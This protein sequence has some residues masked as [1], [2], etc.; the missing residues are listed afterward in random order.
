MEKSR[1]SFDKEF[2]NH[3]LASMAPEVRTSNGQLPSDCMGDSSDS[4]DDR[5]DSFPGFLFLSEGARKEL[6]HYKYRGCDKS[7]LY[8]YIL[9]PLAQWLVD[10]VV[11]RN[12]AP[13]TITL[14]G[15]V[16]MITAYLAYWFYVPTLE[17]VE[18]PPR[19]IFLWNSISILAYQTLDN[20][21]GKQARRTGS[22]SPLGLLF[23]H[24]CDAINSTFGS[25]NWIIGMGLVP[26]ENLLACWT[27]LF[28]PFML[29]YVS[30]W[31]Q[32]NTGEL[33]L[34]IMNGPNEGLVGAA[35]LSLT[36]YWLGTSFWQETSWYEGLQWIMPTF[37]PVLRNCDFVILASLFGFLQEVLIKTYLVT[38]DHPGSGTGLL[39][40]AVF[41]LC[42][43][44]I[45]IVD[46]NVWL[47]I[48][49]TSLH[50]AM[51]LFTEMST[52]IMLAH[53]TGQRFQSFRLHL[54]PLVGIALWIRTMGYNPLLRYLLLAYT[55]TLAVYLMM[56][57]VLV[58]QEI[59]RVL[60]IWCFDIVSPYPK[61]TATKSKSHTK[62]D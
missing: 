50:L 55:W 3:T 60:K 18:D 58:I 9:S 42:F 38:R 11:P 47:S 51:I 40:F 48:P 39:P 27:L 33:I 32:Q 19:W 30:T 49:R 25:A 16:W 12:V 23:D 1:K 15:L 34:P 53:V 13:N 59:C 10:H 17:I 44:W 2:Q 7:L 6:P 56:K 20:M 36:S 26:R 14:I 24:G 52:E 43:L 54:V 22:S 4:D 35:L 31:E 41:S 62:K 57:T 37:V 29:F 8:Q 5:G 46:P 28:G 61:N 21:D 45:G